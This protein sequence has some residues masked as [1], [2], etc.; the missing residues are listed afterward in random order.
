MGLSVAGMNSKLA[1]KRK[2]NLEERIDS[3]KA[4]IKEKRAKT[5]KEKVESLSQKEND[6]SKKAQCL[7]WK[8]A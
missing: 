2:C 1:F 8:A 6:Q 7:E 3:V 4:Y 5:I